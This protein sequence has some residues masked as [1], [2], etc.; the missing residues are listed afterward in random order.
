MRD[1]CLCFA[2]PR[3]EDSTH[4]LALAEGQIR[5]DWEL[6]SVAF[7][8]TVPTE[9]LEDGDSNR[10]VLSPLHVGSRNGTG[11]SS[12]L[13]DAWRRAGS[14]QGGRRKGQRWLLEEQKQSRQRRG[15]RP[16]SQRLARWLASSVR[17]LA[18]S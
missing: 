13:D 11:S 8:L 16:L 1:R 7:W 14:C 9:A 15:V 17:P 12:R 4:F 2:L 10:R 6:P 5:L 18:G 3:L